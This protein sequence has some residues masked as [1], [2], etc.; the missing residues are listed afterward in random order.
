MASPKS[1]AAFRERTGKY[2]RALQK[3][4]RESGAEFVVYMIHYLWLFDDEPFYRHAGDAAWHA[5]A[6]RYGCDQHD[7][8]PYNRF[9]EGYLEENQIPFHNSYD[10][11]KREKRARPK[12]KLWSFD[13]YHFSEAGHKVVADELLSVLEPYVSARGSRR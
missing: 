1:Q 2:V 7:L 12:V 13:D 8:E 10:R 5:E 3:M 9:V 4:T 11:F 6:K